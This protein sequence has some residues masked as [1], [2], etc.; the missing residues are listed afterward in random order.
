MKEILFDKSFASHPKSIFWSAKNTITP[1]KVYLNSH[2]KYW[3]ECYE[4]NHSF[5]SQLANIINGHW[6][7]YCS[8]INY[9]IVNLVLIKVFQRVF[10]GVPRILSHQI[11]YLKILI[12]NIGLIVMNVIILLKLH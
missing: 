2:D 11:K 7:P 9:A 5:E 4:C 12:R 10:S 6:C 3:F 1:D 8:I